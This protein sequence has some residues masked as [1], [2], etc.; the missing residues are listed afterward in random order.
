MENRKPATLC[1]QTILW[2]IAL[3]CRG[4]FVILFVTSGLWSTPVYAKSAPPHIVSMTKELLLATRDD[5]KAAIGDDEQAQRLQHIYRL[6]KQ[7]GLYNWPLKP[8]MREGFVPK[9]AAVFGLS[10]IGSAEAEKF[11]KFLEAQTGGRSDAAIDELYTALGRARAV[12]AERERVVDGWNTLWAQTWAGVSLTHE[13]EASRGPQTISLTWDMDHARFAIKILEEDDATNQEMQ[14]TITGLVGF[15]FDQQ[16][17]NLIVSV[18]PAQMPITSGDPGLQSASAQPRPGGETSPEERPENQDQIDAKRERI[19]AIKSDKAHIWEDTRTGET[20]RQQR[21]RKLKEP[22]E[23]IGEGYAES[24]ADEKI[25]RLEREIAELEGRAP[26]A[27]PEPTPAAEPEPTPAGGEAAPTAAASADDAAPRP[28]SAPGGGGIRGPFFAFSKTVFF[29]DEPVLHTLFSDWKDRHFSTIPSGDCRRIPGTDKYSMYLGSP[30]CWARDVNPIVDIQVVY[31][32]DSQLRHAGTVRIIRRDRLL[33]GA[34]KIV[35]GERQP[36]GQEMIVEVDIPDQLIAGEV[37]GEANRDDKRNFFLDIVAA[38]RPVRGGAV[39]PERVVETYSIKAGH[40]RFVITETR[41]LMPGLYHARLRADSFAVDHARLLVTVDALPGSV[42]LTSEEPLSAGEDITVVFDAPPLLHREFDYSIEIVR[43]LE[44]GRA[45]RVVWDRVNNGRQS[46]VP[47]EFLNGVAVGG[48][49]AIRLILSRSDWR[50]QRYPDPDSNRKE[51]NSPSDYTTNYIID[52]LVV[53]FGAVKPGSYD[54][55]FS[56]AGE[57]HYTYEG[58]AEGVEGRQIPIDF[59]IPTWRP[60][61]NEYY[62]RLYRVEKIPEGRNYLMIPLGSFE[63]D[64]VKQWP[65]EMD[66]K[67]SWNIEGDLPPGLYALTIPSPPNLEWQRYIEIVPRFSTIKLSL[68]EKRRFQY[69]EPIPVSLAVPDSVSPDIRNQK[70]VLE[71]MKVGGHVLGCAIEHPALNTD[72]RH[73]RRV[74]IEPSDLSHTVTMEPTDEVGLYLLRL[75][76]FD[77]GATLDEVALEVVSEPLSNVINL[78]GGPHYSYNSINAEYKGV[79]TPPLVRVQIKL[80]PDH[81]LA[82]EH[83]TYAGGR[84]SNASL[85]TGF[86]KHGAIAV[87]GATSFPFG[88]LDPYSLKLNGGQG[89]VEREPGSLGS[90]EF[91]LYHRYTESREILVASAPFTI[92]DGASTFALGHGLE[93]ISLRNDLITPDNPWPPVG[94]YLDGNNCEPEVAPVETMD[95]RFVRQEEGE[96]V[97]VGHPLK[98]GEAFYLE[99]K[100]EEPA[101]KNSYLARVSGPN[102]S[103]E[104]VALF[105]TEDN[106]RTVRSE[107][108][109]FIWDSPEGANGTTQ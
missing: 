27:G 40:S 73:H 90:Y 72:A 1:I 16:A 47:I 58:R 98:F 87:G 69:A 105:L 88:G 22:F 89:A 45:Q 84:R 34:V 100:L 99:G 64:L 33:P 95:L 85:V 79:D 38:G 57:G 3:A 42:K 5:F 56:I 28:E 14:T 63:G 109:Y 78:V 55:V 77:S 37:N 65:L 103:E 18:R 8:F 43:L 82:I 83:E 75:S 35:G 11:I 50:R 67:N 32:Y 107:L 106:P 94:E 46:G 44:N 15:E 23:Y 76:S 101:A 12:G 96:F 7:E 2:P 41:I 24:D 80:P 4:A 51:I 30:G 68:G 9:M 13:I 29:H 74:I 62:A 81:P 60:D 61:N 20:V 21:F 52:S 48:R 19:E 93:S 71:L 31:P 59:F 66:R 49:Y 108:L 97:P 86:F 39:E 102:G 92:A 104:E 6:L 25:R 26:T 10:Q 17:Q 91:R 53:Q 54:T 70:L 36:L